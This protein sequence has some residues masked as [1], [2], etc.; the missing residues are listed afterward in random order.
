MAKGIWQVWTENEEESARQGV[1]VDE[2]ILF[3][4]TESQ[5]KTFAK[6]IKNAHIGYDCERKYIPEKGDIWKQKD[7]EIISIR[8]I[9]V[10]KKNKTVKAEVISNR[11]GSVG[12][13][14]NYRFDQI[15]DYWK[16]KNP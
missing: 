1:I 4:G 3:S 7:D 6:K 13:V 2:K 5:C 12:Q 11:H 15:N 10:S 9:S 8:V 16:P 14:L